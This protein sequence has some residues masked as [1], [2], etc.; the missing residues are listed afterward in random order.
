MELLFINI[1][2]WIFTITLC[3][4]HEIL[5]LSLTL[6]NLDTCMYI[7]MKQYIIAVKSSVRQTDITLKSFLWYWSSKR[8]NLKKKK[9]S[10]H[11]YLPGEKMTWP[12]PHMNETSF[13]IYTSDILHHAFPVADGRNFSDS[14]KSL[15]GNCFRCNSS[16]LLSSIDLKIQ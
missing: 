10:T 8:A 14:F 15:H 4:F 13:C 16:P 9:K 3:C 2:T 12:W 1:V 5:L 11:C 7:Y 6:F